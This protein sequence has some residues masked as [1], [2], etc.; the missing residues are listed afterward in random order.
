MLSAPTDFFS[1][2]AVAVDSAGSPIDVVDDEPHRGARCTGHFL[3]E[4]VVGDPEEKESGRWPA[5]ALALQGTGRWP[6]I[7]AFHRH[8]SSC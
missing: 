7:Q 2:S 1:A 3:V 5:L 6:F 4:D 8:M